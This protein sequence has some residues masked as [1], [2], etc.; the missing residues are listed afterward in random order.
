[1]TFMYLFHL[2]WPNG[3]ANCISEAKFVMFSTASDFGVFGIVPVAWPVDGRIAGSGGIEAG[4]PPALSATT[5]APSGLCAS[6]N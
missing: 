1:M 6:K 3:F 4:G 5:S 2:N